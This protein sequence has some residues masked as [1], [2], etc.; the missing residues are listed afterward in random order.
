MKKSFSLIPGLL[1]TA[2]LVACSLPQAAVETPFPDSTSVYSTVS[3]RLTA[4]GAGGT[5]QMPTQAQSATPPQ[6]PTPLMPPLTA[7]PPGFDMPTLTLPG[8]RTPGATVIPAPCDLAAP[9][10]PY[11]DIT[12]PDGTRLKPG[13][14]FSKTWRLVNAGSCAWTKDYAIVWFSGEVFGAVREQPVGE[15]VRPGQSIDITVDMVAPKGAGTHQSNWKLRNQRSVLFGIGPTGDAP[16]WVRIEVEEAA[17]PTP[18]SLPSPTA[19]PTLAAL[20][21]G[22]QE[23][24]VGGSFDLDTARL[25]SGVGDDLALQKVDVGGFVLAPI[26]NARLAEMGTQTPGDLECRT[27]NLS[28]AAV[29]A[30]TLKEGVTWC[31]RTSQGLPGYLRLKTI[32]LKDMKLTFEFLTWAIP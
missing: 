9:G 30:V 14:D 29:P 20:V 32:A 19:T 8:T 25:L 13:Q 7:T 3:A 28:A 4:T 11:V 2:L 12:I 1:M 22:T 18:T 31:Y 16:F 10:R 17:T 23:L 21:K 26:N 6:T 24:G 15:T 27:A 5:P